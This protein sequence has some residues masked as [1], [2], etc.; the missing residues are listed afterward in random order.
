MRVFIYAYMLCLQTVK[1]QMSALMS[2]SIDR[3]HLIIQTHC[4]SVRYVF[5]DACNHYAIM[6]KIQT[7]IRILIMVFEQH[8][9]SVYVNK[10]ISL[11]FH[12][13]ARPI[14]PILLFHPKRILNCVG[15]LNNTITNSLVFFYLYIC[16]CTH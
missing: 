10:L 15:H 4:Q 1:I 14:L 9:W 13:F 11:K 8:S 2:C 5:C 12:I 7:G 6:T 3:L 16:I